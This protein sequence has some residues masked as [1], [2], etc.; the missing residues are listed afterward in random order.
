MIRR[1]L[2]VAALVALA[3]CAYRPGYE[4]PITRSLSW[5][6][7]VG[8]ADIREAC[9]PGSP[10]RYRFV[11]NGDYDEQIRTYDITVGADGGAVMNARVRGETDVT[12]AFSMTDPLGPW[13]GWE[14]EQR[15]SPEEMAEL[16][17]DIDSSGIM[18]PGP[19][20]LRL[21]SDEH[22][23]VG[24]ACVDGKFHLNA[25][26][27][28]SARYA[29]LSFPAF[30]VQHDPTGVPINPPSK[31]RE[32]FPN[33]PTFERVGNRFFEFRLADNRLLGASAILGR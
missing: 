33:P 31:V 28:P 10:E 7:Y 4:D 9:V 24:V 30:L 13:R 18:S 12:R 3:G 15:L 25:W 8:S 21:V 6:S 20:G 11:Y 32:I 26:K 2:A 27:Y 5:F 19:E 23:W 1:T 16:R 17:S 29:A 22:Y 14:G